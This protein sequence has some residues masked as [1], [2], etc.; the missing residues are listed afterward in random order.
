MPFIPLTRFTPLKRVTPALRT[1]ATRFHEETLMTMPAKPYDHPSAWKGKD[2]RERSDWIVTLNDGDV[3]ELETALAHAKA[4]GIGIPALTS[5]NFPL[6]ALQARVDAIRAELE[7][8]RGFVLIRGLPVAKYSKSDAALIYWGIGAHLGPA[9]AQNAQGDMLGHVRD[10]GADWKTDM[11]AR[12]YQTR[13]HLPFHND[14]TDVVGLLCLRK[15]KSGGKSRI[16]S[17]TAVHN[18]MLARRPDLW[19]VLHQPFHVDRRGEESPGQKPYYITPCFTYHEGR[20]F[21]RYNR[22]FI[23]S[24]QRFPEVPRLTPEQIEALDLMDQLCS[25]SDFYLDMAFEPGDMQFICNYVTLHSRTD[26][27]D[28]PEPDRKRH[29]LRLWLRTKGFASLPQAFADRNED[30]IAWQK[31]PKPPVF[32]TAEITAEL[33]H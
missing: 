11:K 8:G 18:E 10:L 30:M 14:S 13:M 26:Y 5:R 21:I 33:A 3:A 28:W 6:P 16:V 17:S 29:L 2:M 19:E 22:T 20:L 4:R 7:D 23:E 31:Q 25:D 27:E 32:D 12:G 15:A 9:F 24:A 1:S